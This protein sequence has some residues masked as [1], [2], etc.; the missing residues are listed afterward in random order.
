MIS[1]IS[2]NKKNLTELPLVAMRGVVVFPDT[3]NHFDVGRSRSIAAIEEAMKTATPVFLLAQRDI[4]VD[5]PHRDDLYKYGV[6][7]EVQQVLRL[8]DNFIKVLVNCKYRARLVELHDDKAYLSAQVMRAPAQ[9]LRESDAEEADAL[10]RAIREQLDS[11]IEHYPKL[12][13]D[14]VSTAFS[15][16]NPGRLAEYLAFNLNLEY[17]DKQAILEKSGVIPRLELLHSILVRENN[18]LDIE[19]DINEKVQESIDQNQREYYLREQLKVLSNELGDGTDAISDADEYRSKIKA[20]PL[21]EEYQKKLRKEV[22]RLIQTPPN[23]QES[24]VIRTYLDTV[25]GL[26]WNKF[27]DDSFDLAQAQK[28][29]D[30]DHYGLEKVK[31]RIIEHLAVRSLTDDISGQILCLVGPPGVGKTS[32]ARSIAECMKRKFVRMSLGG[33]KDESEIRG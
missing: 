4:A 18:V 8:S 20:L 27:S 22:E 1:K 15:N 10:V 28:I 9:Q 14:I 6:V 23:S 33:I 25:V 12:S 29:L 19:K 21:G 13:D 26:P 16:G 11:Y 3:V 24:A 5:E 32:I 7:A 30:R 17:T 31:E 2:I